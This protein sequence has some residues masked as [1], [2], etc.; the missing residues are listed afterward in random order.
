[1]SST[2]SALRA[3]L[4]PGEGHASPRPAARLSALEDL[5][6]GDRQ[7]GGESRTAR[8]GGRLLRGVI[9]LLILVLWQA[10]CGLGLVSAYV[11][12][13]PTDI[14]NGFV[15]LLRT[16]DLQSAI[17]VSLSRSAVGLAV[18]GSVGLVLGLFA[19]LWRV[20]EQVFDA[21]MQMLRTIPFIALIPLFITWFG[22]DEFSKVALITA[23]S[24][25]PMY[26]NTY[27]GVR[28][29]DPKLIEAGQTFGLSHRQIAL[30]IILPTALPSI[31]IGLRY[32]A[33]I[34]LLALVAAEQINAQE[35]IG[36]ILVNANQNQRPDLII[37]GIIV[38]AAL[39]I[40]TDMI[41]RGIEALALPWRPHLV[42]A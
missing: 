28:G 35:G 32:A 9:P 40:I 8:W 14:V 27:A 33:G 22:I 42:L 23:A 36:Y 20:G 15:E 34:S 13:S 11:L 1:M 17:P 26:L 39:G 10:I 5:S 16:G 2:T 37:A 30:R 12:P 41:M 25:F 31:L 29:V 4:D 19:G 24:I 6:P 21:P 38:Y 3:T 18:G 7:Q